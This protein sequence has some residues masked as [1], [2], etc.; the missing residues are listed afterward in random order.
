M[1]AAKPCHRCGGAKAPGAGQRYC[2]PCRDTSRQEA[3][4]RRRNAEREASAERRAQ[5]PQT[6]EGQRR[7]GRCATDLPIAS[8]GTRGKRM[9][10]YCKPCSSAYNH[11]RT[12]RIQFGLTPADYQGLLDIQGGRC[13]ICECRPRT[14]RLAVDHDHKTGVIRGLLCTRCN[15][16]LLGAAHESTSMLRRAARY[17]E[18]PPAVT[19]Q[20]VPVSDLD[21]I[22]LALDAAEPDAAGLLHADIDGNV[23]M[24]GSTFIQLLKEAGY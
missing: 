20:P 22:E 13:A 14:R 1:A 3:E 18:A 17:L 11:E 16:K 23:V 21:R 6:P 9:A 24:A 12:L 5:L 7:C 19:A 2:I 8:F 10:G 4:A 15:H